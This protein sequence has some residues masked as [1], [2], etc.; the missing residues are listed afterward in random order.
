MK[1]IIIINV[2]CQHPEVSI[3]DR[4]GIKGTTVV[5]LRVVQFNKNTQVSNLIRFL[6][7]RENQE[8]YVL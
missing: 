3:E 8:N 6:F 4:S 7:R 5:F 2:K 1:L